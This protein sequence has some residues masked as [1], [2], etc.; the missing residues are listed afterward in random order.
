[1]NIIAGRVMT[2]MWIVNSWACTP[3]SVPWTGSHKSIQPEQDT[4]MIRIEL[5]LPK[6]ESKKIHWP[7]LDGYAT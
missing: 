3:H 1:M 7:Y 6:V 2:L 4:K 5:K